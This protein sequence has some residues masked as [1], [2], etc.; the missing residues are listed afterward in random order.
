MRSEHRT[1]TRA[2]VAL[3]M[4]VCLTFS[5]LIPAGAASISAGSRPDNLTISGTKAYIR[6]SKSVL[7]FTGDTYGTGST[8]AVTAG[9]VLQMYSEDFYTASDGL[10]YFS[11]YCNSQRYNVL[12]TDV[13]NDIMSA[14]ELE[15]YITGT[16][17]KQSTYTTLKEPLNL[18]G[19]VRVHALQLA[20]Q[21][22]GYY[23]DKLDGNYGENTTKAVKKFQ[24]ANGLSADGAA[25]V[26][27]Q[28]VIYAMASGSAV[29]GSGS[30]SS[31]SSS[32]GSSSSSSGSSS[33][34][35]GTLKTKVS[36]NLRKSTSTSSARLAVL[37]KGLNLAYIGT[38]VKNGITWYNVRYNGI[39]GWVMGTYVTASGSSS[40][41]SSSSTV[42]PIG[43]V[44]ITKPSTRVRKTANGTKTGTVLAKGTVVSLLA[45][46]V[47]AGGYTW[48][49]IRTSSGLVGFVRGD[50]AAVNSEGG[51]SSGGS[52]A[53]VSNETTFVRLPANTVL[54]TTKTKPSSG[55]YNVSAGTVLRM[56]TTTTYTEG[57][58]EYCTL[59]YNN[60]QYNAVYADVK[61]GI[62]TSGE[63]SSY[64]QS[65]WTASLTS[66]LKRSLNLVGDIRVYALQSAL[67]KLGYYTGKMDG[68]YGTDTES[69]V[70]NFQRKNSLSVDGACGVKTWNKLQASLGTG[71]GS[72]G[73]GSGIVVTDFGTVNSVQK[74]SWNYDDNGGA[75]F[76]KNT[77]AT[78]MD[79]ETGK[80][81]RI[82]RWSG[83]NHADC[84]PATESDTRT[85]CEIVGFPYN[86]NHPTS[87][88]LAKIKADGNADITNYTWPDF[89][90]KF[91]GG[92]NIGSKWDRR[93]ALLN[94]D[95]KVY[96]VSIY[97]FPHGFNGTDSFSNSKFKDNGQYFY[98]MNNY[99]GM[100]CIHFVG[101]KTHGGSS[102]DTKHQEAINKAY[103]YAK[104]LWPTLCK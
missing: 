36:V 67:N 53:P 50:C 102:P 54:F 22:L 52:D 58:T 1:L 15:T 46:G 61:G 68:T 63:L 62:M 99:Y 104:K 51:G 59:Y 19:D 86:S 6:L 90:N 25:G 23:T 103:D 44:T 83:G 48:Y 97:G 73:G 89:K 21:K 93:A 34:I 39:T 42:T 95:G 56:V 26:L 16:L 29:P 28:P 79:V 78:V 9:T 11:V 4:A 3:M 94:V 96:A 24:K 10:A 66:S 60:Q 8:L 55:G 38:A 35:S 72:S 45:N 5:A 87:E 76:P 77:Y 2:W 43:T 12:R 41:G 88:Q 17:W 31:G 33:S 49:N 47:T 85:M 70:R 30:S 65:L 13:L 18:V 92:V 75:L 80:V 32:S 37:P 20:L 81:F 57:G 91:G 101:S 100:M 82:Y 14:G 64:V 40:G 71:G 27:T 69:A 74:A 98:A 84:V 7:L